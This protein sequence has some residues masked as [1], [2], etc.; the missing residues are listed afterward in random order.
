MDEEDKLSSE[1][2]I[3]LILTLRLYVDGKPVDST[4]APKSKEAIDEFLSGIL[5]EQTKKEK[6]RTVFCCMLVC[7][8][9]NTA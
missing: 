7:V 6:K 8:R 3:E 2:R 9:R 5:S 4:A 1:L